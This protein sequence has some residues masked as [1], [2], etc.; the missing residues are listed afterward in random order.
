MAQ[1]KV[2]K[3]QKGPKDP[4]RVGKIKDMLKRNV[5]RKVIALQLKISRQALWQQIRRFNLDKKGNT[6]VYFLRWQRSRNRKALQAPT[7]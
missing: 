5:P 2:A 1:R 7:V 6:D 3:A 4:D